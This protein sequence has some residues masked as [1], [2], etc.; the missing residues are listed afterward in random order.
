MSLFDPERDP[1]IDVQIALEQAR[2]EKKNVLLHLGGDWCILCKRLEAFINEH[3]EL[4]MLRDSHYIVVKVYIGK[5]DPANE[6]FIQH[7]P[8][9]NGVP[10]LYVYNNHGQLLCSQET[11]S[12]E[13]G[14][15]YIRSKLQNFLQ[16]WADWRLTP[17]HSMPSDELERRFVELFF[18][19]NPP[20]TT[21]SA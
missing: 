18:P 2:R 1:F 15:S 21:P 6:E 13:V 14:E 12:F 7:L 5:D 16:E 10:H 20:K 17:F 9:F 19:T 4:R 3:P 8:P 11:E